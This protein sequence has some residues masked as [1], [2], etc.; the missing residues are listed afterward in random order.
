MTCP[1]FGG[2]ADHLQ[3]HYFEKIFE[4]PPGAAD[5]NVRG[6]ATSG[7]HNFEERERSG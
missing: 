2:K 7:N 1:L 5:R 3:A 6:T 4:R